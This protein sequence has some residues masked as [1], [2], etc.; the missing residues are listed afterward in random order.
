MA[1]PTSKTELKD[2]CLRRLGFPVID[3]NVDDDQV[4]DRVDDAIQ[5]FHDFHFDGLSREYL[6]IAIQAGDKANT[7]VTLPDDVVGVTRIF[8]IGSETT[9]SNGT[10]FNMFDIN[11][12]LR[13][14]ELYDF[15]SSSYMYYWIARTHIEMLDQI[16]I[17]Q[18]PIRFNKKM[19]RLYV[20]M[21]WADD[22]IAPGNYMMVE[23][24][25]ALDADTYPKVY[26]DD[27]LKE[28]TTQLIKKQWGE[29]MKKYSNYTLPGGMVINGQQIY[30][31][32]VAEIAKLE[33]KLRDTYEEPPEFLV[34]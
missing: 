14:N 4:D 5:L 18:N 1:K 8:R 33:I 22:E 13:L 30:D 11:Y 9:N 24:T 15:T 20:D 34:G 12:Q 27:W 19:N 21:N 16:L 32:A 28:Y 2:Y 7:Y 25:R 23:C 26:N 6:A 29:N 31:E 17:G 3:I 10:N